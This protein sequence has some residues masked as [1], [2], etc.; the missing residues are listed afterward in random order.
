MNLK[1]SCESGDYKIHTHTHTHASKAR[2]GYNTNMRMKKFKK[3][4]SKT[5]VLIVSSYSVFDV[6]FVFSFYFLLSSH[7]LSFDTYC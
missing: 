4:K 7:C 1:S 2:H 6:L 3:L 5:N